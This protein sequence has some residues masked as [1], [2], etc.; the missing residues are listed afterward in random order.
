VAGEAR[1]ATSG[2]AGLCVSAPTRH[3]DRLRSKSSVL[4]SPAPSYRGLR[5]NLSPGRAATRCEFW[6][7]RKIVL[8]HYGLQ[9]PRRRSR[10]FCRQLAS[11]K[12]NP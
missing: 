5:A 11:C 7:P 4:V 1:D 2:G 3:P 12:V 6:A 10:A 8:Q 9:E